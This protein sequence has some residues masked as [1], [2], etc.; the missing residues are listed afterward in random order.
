MD[1]AARK[2]V[3][4]KLRAAPGHEVSVSEFTHDSFGT[5]VKLDRIINALTELKLEGVVSVRTADADGK[6]VFVLV[7]PDI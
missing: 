2:Y 3:L 7:N 1:E 4:D 6:F 5:P